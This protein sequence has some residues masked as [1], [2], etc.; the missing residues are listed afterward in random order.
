MIRPARRIAVS[1]LVAAVFGAAA[2]AV[3]TPAA[4]AKSPCWKQVQNDWVDDSVIQGT[5]ELH[6]YREAIQH[7]PEDLRVYTGI[8]EAIQ[9]ARQLAARGPI[10]TTQG[11][12]DSSQAADRAPK[13]GLFTKGFDRLG[14]DNADSMPLP[15]L[16]L[17]GLALLMVAAGA[18]GLVS[19]HFR[20]RRVPGA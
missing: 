3:G 11:H 8:V 13:K 15:I 4:S 17:G 2:L 19:R 14:P 1:V 16:I 18:A 10:R 9:A 6:C 20:P 7:V 12:N 5:Y